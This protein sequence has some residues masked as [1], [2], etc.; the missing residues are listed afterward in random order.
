MLDTNIII[1]IMVFDSKL[2]KDLLLKIN[3][4]YKLV[5]SSVII[6]ELND[7]IKNKFPGKTTFVNIFLKKLN[8]EFYILDKNDYYNNDFYIRDK[9][10]LPILQSAIKSKCDIF[11]TGDKDFYGLLIPGLTIISPRDFINRY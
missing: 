10:D 5:L 8:Y 3:D 6:D 11:I 7:V 1:S 2:L 4:N 9:N